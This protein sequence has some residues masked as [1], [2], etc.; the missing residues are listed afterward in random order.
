LIA[1]LVGFSLGFG[2]PDQTEE[3]SPHP[4]G[5]DEVET[6]LEAAWQE[7]DPVR[8]VALFEGIMRDFSDD[9][10]VL[11]SAARGRFESMSAFSDRFSTAN[12]VDAAGDLERVV[13]N[14]PVPDDNPLE[15]A[16]T[17]LQISKALA[18]RSPDR[19]LESAARGVGFVE[20]VWPTTDQVR[21]EERYLFWPGMI[22]AYGARGDW[23]AARRVCDA[24]LEIVDAGRISG[25]VLL[26][27]DEAAARRECGRI[28]ERT[29]SVDEARMQL[30]LAAAI[31]HRWKEETAAFS[32]RHPLAG[33]PAK[34][35]K[36]AL[37]RAEMQ[38]R[39]RRDRQVKQELL[40]SEERRPAPGFMLK[41]LAGRAVSLSD[42][43][44]RALVLSYWA[45]WCGPCIGEIKELEMAYRK[46]RRSSR[47][48]FAAVSIDTDRGKVPGFL[49]AH[50]ITLP[51][52]LSDG[53]VEVADGL[54][55]V[56][57][58]Y[59]I[60]AAGCIRFLRDGWIDDGYGL[61]RIDWMIEAV[62]RYPVPPRPHPSR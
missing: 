32:G 55:G 21:L 59:V 18:E 50:G 45:T 47:V 57:I 41:D 35:F 22:R 1:L 13:S 29:G 54:D 52:L 26:A 61:K 9:S 11:A 6:R 16:R 30:G 10:R 58:L 17:M 2:V 4:R 27:I 8:S 12:L 39:G 44:G 28:L 36:A 25:S 34:E 19:A 53:E 42:F 15:Y 33:I 20:S 31:D 3:T 37:A 60:D 5:R 14:R 7:R 38:L 51:V 49:K 56:P 24:L 48:A 62:L 40:A 46:Y 23:K 43:R